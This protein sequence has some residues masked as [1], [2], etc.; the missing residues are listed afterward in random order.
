MTFTKSALKQVEKIICMYM[1]GKLL[2][3]NSF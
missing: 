2:G 1:G 3:D